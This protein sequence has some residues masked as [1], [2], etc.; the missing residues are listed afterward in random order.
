MT[1]PKRC[2]EPMCGS[3][4]QPSG[5]ANDKAFAKARNAQCVF[6]LVVSRIFKAKLPKPRTRQPADDNWNRLLGE[7]LG[8]AET[9]KKETALS[10]LKADAATQSS[11]C[12]WQR[13]PEVTASCTASSSN[14]ED[15][16]PE[17]FG[18][19]RT[20]AHTAIGMLPHQSQAD[21]M[22]VRD[23][24]GTGVII[25]THLGDTVA[26]LKEHIY[27]RTGIPADLQ[28]LSYSGKTLEDGH[29]RAY[30]GLGP[31]A[32]VVLSPSL[33]GISALA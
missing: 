32:T 9:M 11:N 7:E 20:N 26:D 23:Q 31:F 25:D 27:Q 3:S 24:A 13:D 5:S 2:D 12:Y 30:Y 18:I 4:R 15:M 14:Q 29:P 22:E 33:T 19:Y 21:S 1:S 10:Q 28:S 8:M 17:P 6:K 16:V